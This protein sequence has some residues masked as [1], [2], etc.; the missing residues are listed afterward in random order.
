MN[1][2]RYRIIF[3]H[4]RGMFIA[5]AEIV[6]SKTKQAGQ[7]Q[8][9]ME[10]DSVTSSV[11]PIH[12]KKLNPLNFAVIGCLGALVISL[13]MSS[14]AETQIIADKGAPTSQQPTI[15]NSANGTTQ[16]NIQ[17]PSAGGVSRN[18]YTQFDV[19]QE[20]AIL[21]N[22]RNNTQTQIGGW[23]QGNPWL[24]TGEAKVI[25]NEVNSSNP[26]QLKGYI[27]VAGK[28]AQVVIANP[29]GLICDGCG[30]INADRFTLT[31]GQAVM[32][33]G[34]LE[35]FRVRE[36]QVTIEG[37]GLNGSLTPY[38]DIYARALKVNAGL[39]ANELG[40][41]L[42]QNDIQVKDQ[43]TPKITATTGP[44]STPQPNFA[45][46]V[47]QLGGMYAGKIFL[48]GT[49][50]GLGVRNAG[51]INST[52]ST[53]TLN[54]NG[55]LVNNGNLIA[56]KDQVQ[57]K[58]QNIQNT[59][60]ISS[61][62][63]QISVESQNLNNSG[64]ISSADELH[65]QNQNTITNSG[66]LNAA[67]IAINSKNLKNRGSIE[68]TGIQGLD[69]KSGSMTNLGGKIG[70][71]KNTTGGGTG[72]SVPTVPT[73]PS[74]DGGSLEVATPIDTTP[75]T[76]D[77]GYIHVQEQLNNDQGAIIANGGVDLDSQNGLDNQGG[78]LNLG[79]IHIKGNSFNNNQG[80]LTV[81][82]ADIQTSS[83]TNQQGQLASNSTLNI[84]T[85]SANNKGGKIQSIG[86]LDLAVSGELNNV[87]GQIASGATVNV[88]ASDLKNQ[89]GV[90]YSENQ[91][92]NIKANK[93]IDNTEGLIQAKT[94]LNLN[95]QSLN[96]T[97]GQIV[98][99]QIKQKHVTVNNNQGSIAAQ[100]NL[101]S[102]A[103]QFDNTQGQIH[104][105]SIKLQHDQLKNTGSVYADQDL[106]VTG[107]N[108]QN[109]GT[110]GAGKN[111]QITSSTLEHSVGGLIAAGL[112][113]E[114]KLGDAGDVTIRS[115]QVGL[116]GQTLAGG[117]LKVQA[118]SNIDAAKGQLQA[119]NIELDSVTGN[120]STQAGSVVA[121]NQLKLT[122][123]NLINNQQGLLSSQDLIL[124]A[125]QLDNSQG[126]I[127][128]TGNNEFT[129]DFVN[130]LNNKAGEISSN[131]S[132]INLNTSALN[133]ETGK[134][135]HA[136]NQQLNI[137]ADQ[138]QGAQGQILS[139]GQLLLKGGQVVLDGATTSANQ[140]NI[141]ADSLS[142][143]KGQ[144]VQSGTLNPLTLAIKDQMNNQLGFIQ[145]QSGL[146]LKTT[147]LH[148]QGGQLS[149]ALNYDVQLDV[150]GLLDNSQSGKIYAGQNGII[151]AGSINNS[152]NGLISAQ[153]ALTLTSL[154][155][156]NNQSGKIVAN[157]DVTLTSDGVDNS[158]GQI[159]SSQGIVA[160]NAGSGVVNNT[161]GTLQ[162]E[163]DLSVSADQIN[164]QSGLMNS[165]SSLAL[166]SRKD[167]NNKSGQ[168]IAK[169]DVTTQSQ[170]LANDLGQIGS[171]QGN[172]SLDAGLGDLSNQSGKI[173]AAQDLTLS[174][175][176][177]DNQSGLISAQKH[178]ALK[179]Q[180]VN[181]LKGQIQ[182]GDAIEIMGQSLNNQ[183][184][185]IETNADLTLNIT[186]ALDNSQSGKLT[187]NTTKITAGSINNS[188]KGQINATDALTVLS[189]QEINN[190]TGVMA[191]NQN[192]SIQSQ[193]LD[194]TSG[195][196]G[197]VQG[198]LTI[199]AQKEKLLNTSGS[200]QAGTSL[201][202]TSGGLNNDSGTILALTDNTITSTDDISNK[203]GKIASNAHTTITTQNLNNQAG[204]IQSGSGS[205]LDLVINGAL[206]NSQAGHLLSGAGL[207]LKVNTLDNSQQGQISAQDALNIISAGLINNQAGTLVANQNV[208][209]S[210]KG[211]NN[212]Q[213]QIGSIQG[214]LAIDA[215]DQALTNQS[216]VLQAK[217]DLTAKALSIDS[218]EG[219]IISQA[220]ID[221]Q[222]LKEI[223][224]Q[225][226]IISADQGIQVKSTG[227]NNNLGQIS[228]AQGNIVLN[229]GQGVLSNQTGKVIAGQALQLSAGQVD[230][231]QTGQLNSQTTLDIQA[232]KD[233]NNQSGIIAAN[234]QVN[235]N[236]QGLNNNQGQIVSLNDALTVNS[237]SGVLD[238]QSGTLQAKGDIQLNAEQVN[239]QSGL[240]SS[241]AGIDLQV[242]QLVDNSSGQIIANNAVQIQSQGLKNNQGQIASV[243]DVLNINSGS[244]TLENQ[245]GLLQA[246]GDIQLT[247]DRLLNQSGLIN[248]QGKLSAQINQDI[249][250][251]AGQIV[252]NQAVQLNSQG[253]NNNAGQV[254]SVAGHVILDAGSGDLS[255]QSGKI[256]S[257][258]DLTLNAQHV[259]NQSGLISAQQQ[260]VLN[261][262][263][264]NNL[265]GQIISGTNLTFVG[266]DLNNQGGLLQTNADLDLNLS[267]V[268]DNSLA[269]QLYS[270]GQTTIKAASVDNSAQG[271]INSQGD[272]NI[273]TAQDINNTEGVI[274]A[275]KQMQLKSQG[276][277]N[278]AG[279]I[280]TEQGD[281]LI[282]T[283]DL[284]LNNGTGAI[285]SGK[286]L[287]LDV[288][289]LTNSGVI[290][291]LDQLTL[292]SQGDVNNDN[293]QILSNQQLLLTSQ[294]LSN[295]AGIIQ[296]GEQA[297]LDLTI[298]GVLNNQTGQIHGGANTQIHAN[299]INNSQQGQISAQDALNIISAGLV[300]NQAGQMI[301][302]QNVTLTSQ[303]LNNN[304]GQ[305]GSI[306]GSLTVDA[307]NQALS[308]QSGTLQAKSDVSV[309][310]L[311]IDNTVGQI[312]TQGN[313]NLLSQQS[314]N[315][316][317]G[318]IVGD[319]SININSQGLNNNQGQI[320]TQGDLTVQAGTQVL[321]NQTGLLQAGQN[322]NISAA[323]IDNLLSGQI[324]AQGSAIL[325][326]TG[327]VNNETGTI[328]ANQDITLTSQGLNNTQGQIGSVVGSLNLDS[329]QQILNNQSGSLLS[330]HQINIHAA[331]LNN[332]QGQIV[333]QQVLDIDA[334]LQALNNQ[335]GLISSDTVN[336]TSGLL[337]NDQGLIQSNS[338]MMIDTQGQSLI[339]TNSGTQG[340]LLSQ[341]NL[342]LKN[343][344]L[345]DNKLGYLA[346]GQ[347]LDISANQV[348]NSGGTL[349]AAQN[350]KLQGIGQNQL[351]NNQSGQILSMGDMQLSVE[352]INNQ[353]K[354]A[355][356]DADSH[357][358]ATGQLD[359]QTQQ[360]DNQNTL[361]ADTVQ[362]ID[363]GNL[364]LNAA[365]VNNQSGAIR[366]SQ[367][368]QLNISQQLNNQSSEIS[369]V[370]QLGIQGDQL[371]MNNLNGQLLAGE[372]L[373]INAK[374]LTGDGKV[375]SLGNADIQLKDSYQHN[376]TA[377]LQ[378]NQNLSLTSAGDINNDG[379]INAGNQ[380]QLSAVNISNSNNAK[381]ESH[382]TQ[383]IAQQQINNTGLINGDLTTLTADTVNNQGTGRI[384]GT[385]LAIS[386]NTLN[387]LPD[388]NGTAPVIASRGDMN[389]GVNVL[390]NL[391]N[392]QDYDSQALIFSAGNLYLGGALDENRKATGQATVINNESAT[393]ES[394]GDMRLSTQT[395]NNIN[396][397][398]STHEVEVSRQE[399]LNK[400]FD[401]VWANFD[402]TVF[403]YMHPGE[404]SSSYDYDE[405]ITETQVLTSAPAK[406]IAGGNMDLSGSQVINDK[407]QIFAGGNLT[408]TGG[409][410]TNTEVLGNRET[411]VSGWQHLYE[412]RSGKDF[413]G[414]YQF[415]FS[416]VETIK[417][418]VS[419]TIGHYPLNQTNQ[420]ITRV[421]NNTSSNNITSAQTNT[422]NVN[423][424][425]GTDQTTDVGQAGTSQGQN[426]SV[427]DSGQTAQGTDA[428]TTSQNP[429][430]SQTTQNNDVTVSTS[431]VDVADAQKAQGQ[432]LVSAQP[433]AV[434][435]DIQVSD[436]NQD[437]A[438]TQAKNN[439]TQVSV[440]EQLQGQ[441]A[442]QVSE[443]STT[444]QANAPDQAGTG[445]QLEIRTI[446]NSQF[447]VANNALYRVGADSK[448]GYLIE[449]DPSFTNYNQWLSSD[450]ML[451]AL[452]LDPALQQKRLGDGFYEQRMVQD[453]IANLTGYRFL[454]GYGSDEEQ[455]KALMNN[456]VTYAK[457]YGLRPG[458]ALT[459]AQIA[460]LTSDIVWLVEKDVT[461]PDGTQ[462]KALAPQV[463]VKARV[464]DLKGDGTLLSGNSIKFN[465]DGDLLNTATIAGREAVQITADNVNNLMGRI[466]GNT[467]DITSKKDLNNIG[468]SI[469]AKDAMAMNVGGNLNVT[470]TTRTTDTQVGGFSAS[471]TG[472]DRVAGLYVGDIQA[473]A[474]DLNKATFVLNVAG[475]SVLKG[476]EINNSNGATLIN[477][478]GNVDIGTVQTGY[479]LGT[480][481]DARNN[482]VS[483]KTQDVG[484]QINS[485]GSLL[486][487]GQNIN[488]KGSGLNSQATTQLAAVKQLNIEEGRQTSQLDSQWYSKRKG[489]L[490][491]K[492]DTGSIHDQA[493]EA[494]ASTIG[495]KKVILDAN[496]INI[497]GSQVVSDDLTQIQAK[498]N[499]SITTAENQYSNQFEQ[500]VKKSGFKASLS[501]GVASVGYGKSSLNTK[502]DGKSTTLTQ[503]VIRSKT[504]DTTIIAGKDLTTEAA[505][506]DAGKDLNLKGANVNLNAGYTTDEQHSEVHSKQS[507]ISVGVTYSPAMA[508]AAAYKNSMNNGQFSDSAVGQV[509][510]Q[511]EAARKASMAAM[512]LVTIQAG[513]KKTNEVSNTSSTQAVITQATAKGNLNIIATEGS[514]NSQGAQ[515][516]AEGDALLHAKEN[517]NLNVA[518]SHS[519]QT[520]DRKQS[521][522]S[523]D[524]RDW[525]APAGT[526]KN[527]N[528]GD[529]R[530]TQT[531]VTQLS[532][533]GKTTLQT[534][535]GDINI[536]GSSVASKGDVN[537]HAAR[538]INIKSS[539]NSQSQSEQSSNKGIGSAQISDTEQFYGYMSGKSQ[540]TSN[541]VEQ[542]RSQVGSLEGNVN[543]QA[544]RQYTQQVADVIAAKDLNIKA[545][546]IQVLEGHN[547]G[548]SSENSKDLKVGQFSRVSSPLIDLVNAAD[549][550]TKSQADDRT[551]ALQAIAAGAQGY[552]TYSDIKGGALF[553]AES[554]I[555]FSTSNNQQN[556]SYATSQ[557]NNLKAGGNVNL[558]STHGDIHLQNTQV[559]AEDKI[560]LD[561][562]KNIVLESGQSQNKADGKNSNAGLSV[563]VGASVGAQTG[564]YI[565]GEAGF[566]K[567]SNHLDS[568]THNQTTLDAKN[569]SLTSKGDTTLRGAQAKA[570]RI[571]ANVGGQLKVESLQ[572]TVEQN[573][574]QTG[575]GG[576][577]QASFG[578]AWQASGNFSS[579]KASGDSN[580]VNQQSGLFAGNGGYHVKADSV[581]LKGGAIVSTATKDKND[582]TTNRL[583]FSN[584]ENQSQYDA[585]TVSLSGGTSLGKGKTGDSKASTPTNNDNWRNA[586]SFSPSLPQHE[587]DKD[588]S[589]TYAT[590]SEGNI[591]VGGKSTTVEQLGIHSDASTANR[592]V[593]TLPNLQ[594]IL[595]K[596]KTVAD[597]TSTI[598]AATRTYS[599][600]QQQQAEKAKNA[601]KQ[602]VLN[603]L[604]LDSDALKYYESLDSAKQE[605]YLRQ[606]SP[607]YAKASDMNQAWGMGGD[608]SRALNAV[609][610]AVTGA[611]GGQT[612]VQVVANTLA[613]YAANMIGEKFGHG[614]DKNKAA[615]LASHAI[616][617]ATL[618]YLNGGNPAAGGSAAVASE[619]AADYLANQYKDDPA[620]KNGKGEFEPNLLPEN[621]KSSIRDLTAAIGAVVGGTVGDSASNV[622]LAGVIGQNAVENNIDS[623]A[624]RK[625]SQQ[626]MK[627]EL[628]ASCSA[629]GLAPGSAACGQYL[630]NETLTIL[631]KA[632]SLTAD[633]LP[634]I[635]D[636]KGFVEAETVGDYV[637]ASVG[638]V[639]L[640]GDA[641]KDFYKAEK[642]Y[643][644][645]S[646]VGD[647]AKMKAAMQDAVH[648]CSGSTCFTAGT[649]IET[650]QGLKAVE[651]FVGGELVWARNDL[652]L[653]YGYRPVIATKVTAD[654]PIFH[655]TVQNEQ[656]QIDVLE[657]TAEHPFWIKDLGWL[658]A[659]L[660]QS[661]MTLLDRDNQEITIVSQAL[662]SNKLE[663]VYN[664]EVEGFHTYHVG[665]LGVWVHNANC[666]DIKSTNAFVPI[667]PKLNYTV[668]IEN[669]AHGYQNIDVSTKQTFDSN[670]IPK[671][672][673]F[674][675]SYLY[676]SFNENSG[677]LYIQKMAALQPGNATGKEMLSQVIEKIGYSK[678][679]TAKAELAQTNKEAFDNAYKK[680]GNLI[681]AV[682]NTPL[683]KS[684][685]DLGF[686]VKSVENTSGMPKVIFERK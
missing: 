478:Q 487:N 196:I 595:D 4:A 51:S 231:S 54:A 230:N 539:Q 307:G 602:N 290:S 596:Q 295:Q 299:S 581:D 497:R 410:I 101:N 381:I 664:I 66:T 346:S 172:V 615:Q 323:A 566:G 627:K 511:G 592:G 144:M 94:N 656:G 89:S 626:I 649:L 488:I 184:G 159:G 106:T 76:Y 669:K 189:Q 228:S 587:S 240:I 361:V 521:G 265:K 447:K 127:Q 608:K 247:A 150:A 356:T 143:Q 383:L 73:D 425:K 1:K 312:N 622:Q 513:S 163:K 480:V 126:K 57:L 261:T 291:A 83:F 420:D 571:D 376:A 652:T 53:L 234:Q 647:V 183:G 580:S 471:T 221:L 252:A 108:I 611:L 78:Q 489:T 340:G 59:G 133:N 373:N 413:F 311:S 19:G 14:V 441:T 32:N 342:S 502:E 285:Q 153:N 646:K 644:A 111:V 249:D 657:T 33:Q 21:N 409:T 305:I 682:N 658:K 590:L 52:Q 400:Y 237:G 211:L 137:T 427:S 525:A 396:K 470:S 262:Q 667:K 468:G 283:G 102:T 363:A 71:A 515:L 204:M 292:N 457:Q 213:G 275:T 5:V 671:D 100:Q 119:Q 179:V 212:N 29:S 112:D 677:E 442:E 95:S 683:G 428:Q 75:K 675:K 672:G 565:Y 270:G 288:N 82:S 529:G 648:A 620:Y 518:Q 506:L 507:G 337:N 630:R 623:P 486:I 417:L 619:A 190:Q 485:T 481:L 128:H 360:L 552:Q 155:I 421:S 535:Q 483:Q 327:L 92:V 464:G 528:Q 241:E 609:T 557:Q 651:E 416:S 597:A 411:N 631:K 479:K 25:L 477:T 612:D 562:A 543:I 393:I 131:A 676:S 655:V 156:I 328:T 451:D 223:N 30:V 542:Q 567:G 218:T 77:Q 55:D 11:R 222:S 3:S 177:L 434:Q 512:T 472:L 556:S 440:L 637:F 118:Q 534:G 154:G 49:E 448:A 341:G 113:R 157:Q 84:Q 579:S 216:G 310:A 235:L 585:T 549:K 444:D 482:S 537:L 91:A 272:L 132:S 551:Q 217:T 165:Q 170:G 293:G 130:G 650:D 193:G 384:Y 371:V 287:T 681:D 613:P 508:A 37:K 370:K 197:S 276:L 316:T 369:A 88:N 476:A 349:L 510:A 174:A 259:D 70:I 514:I 670:G 319:Q 227:L 286:T 42:G 175:Q 202:I 180:K 7:S 639:P 149:S 452:G 527:K 105:K 618:A 41:V 320:G 238:N 388:A 229:A 10:T 414:D 628:N 659:S 531:T 405:V 377:Q 329:G 13:P 679:K 575:A 79:A 167:I 372:N 314:I 298:N 391:A 318:V 257:A 182:S 176:N 589:T 284:A 419:Q 643:E 110:L 526:F 35:S 141:S 435:S 129:L 686:K 147:T 38:T 564:V 72:G 668:D 408:N 330:G 403:R 226:G 438:N 48:V 208:T 544:G 332:T 31:T 355:S 166:I 124:T 354:L 39:Y 271:Q 640:V 484:S 582:L 504:G 80:E 192:V 404:D 315:N 389:L 81:K 67:R 569:I 501:D 34:Y 406:I 367:N 397:N 498:E 666:C 492:T 536:V 253:L 22:S 358:M 242:N 97:S 63:S 352:H 178:L 282:Q 44:T 161:S 443:A 466:Q 548:S 336:I 338:A 220:K 392:T 24:A 553:K 423:G 246:Q 219:Q 306:Q 598:A 570:D 321:Q 653:E 28:Q 148:N 584:I 171:V 603:Q 269:G 635:G 624:E 135:I 415:S 378:A 60:N 604:G 345:L 125:K 632:G 120:I 138:L 301:A 309:K 245:A 40:T 437:T 426:L 107:Q 394:L 85:Q 325:Q 475:D 232:T 16:V 277:E 333:A 380:L 224:N 422:T 203:A 61:A 614:E 401:G 568:N 206:D 516:S 450:Y 509:M 634:V 344:G 594:T 18:T 173:L 673:K 96:N 522:F 601:E 122:S 533:G 93:A 523:I 455:Y 109:A 462:T 151:Q 98:A 680:S 17:T 243:N 169:Q 578:T 279:Q 359:I 195:Q 90:V 255:N 433:N 334:E 375:L 641:A 263:G 191:A 351:L 207:N 281:I 560:N 474:V 68:Q 264:L 304:Q 289:S 382:D 23:V 491:S 431:Q 26:S 458:I 499:I 99:D 339:N 64:L 142:H 642:A 134:I 201:K 545:Q 160:I 181:N 576:R 140:I 662:I 445:E 520:V 660:L 402:G 490:S 685:R 6:K 663:T 554:G 374:S 436:L 280:G 254:G 616:L 152:L 407:S 250:N 104:A 524:N 114:G 200:L 532:V 558:T 233:I 47:G 461:L 605:E 418:P 116:H 454:E 577:L 187:G 268:L 561:S 654:Q 599:Q 636:I 9:M 251:S 274:V 399:G 115:D 62:T 424:L 412:K 453:Q 446:N 15:L 572:D 87:D 46:D 36:G 439:T 139:N 432:D 86:Q 610:M 186:D 395:I 503:S 194:N 347:N 258:Q 121:Q 593:E 225:Q 117:N 538:D 56:N 625:A 463:Y 146:Q 449:T 573:T 469:Q 278:T 465:L 303:G 267:G 236:S 214:G 638:L 591:K 123:Q 164:N 294:N 494:I 606:Y 322:L 162:A 353:G 74:K 168:I 326:S 300:D 473:G 661:G 368:S 379:T 541:S 366:S 460:Q 210:S 550:A 583:T 335:Q 517:I 215:G 364:N 244:G 495:G 331:G 588:S 365:I 645:A 386:T 248:T 313:I 158:S 209:L 555:G 496:N 547:T 343:V 136:G 456:G 607:D 633:F 684:M 665:E 50:Q 459:P 260:L 586:T 8:G 600:N 65:L 530:N 296:S 2:N 302:N 362:G 559:K 256:I 27:E 308:N 621:V 430:I 505:I 145:S 69:L 205:A 429:D 617:G 199:D 467:V 58:A 198:S 398:F 540:S 273:T 574:K 317:Q 387:N 629:A 43:V 266:Q 185:S 20:G 103:Q 357:I 493:N 678:I 519:E 239:S 563:G 188:N 297:N 385:D 500:T 390:N 350:L 12:Y 348:Q 546:D 45:L 674:T 324:N